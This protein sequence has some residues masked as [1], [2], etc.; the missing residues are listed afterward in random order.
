[1]KTLILLLLTVC[2]ANAQQEK[3]TTKD[4]NLIGK[5][6]HVLETAEQQGDLITEKKKNDKSVFHSD[7]FQPIVGQYT[8]NEAGNIIEKRGFPNNDQ[9]TMYE[10]DTSNKLVTETIYDSKLNN[11]SITPIMVVTY[12]YKKDTIITTKTNEEE[13]TDENLV[14]TQVYKNNQLVQEYTLQK[15]IN[16]YYDSKG[17]LIKKE[18][19]RKRNNQ[20]NSENYEI[21]YE[22]NSVISNFC[23]EQNILKIYYS[24]GLLKFYTSAIRFQEHVYTYDQNGNWITSSVTLDGKPAVKYFRHIDYFE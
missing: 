20:K 18:G 6:K 24:N 11:T 21:K 1:M 13:K 15:S 22:N 23:P 16:Y 19:I 3:I 4:F 10:Y 14:I 9:K 17:T 5:V 12:T 7:V 8:F 2:F